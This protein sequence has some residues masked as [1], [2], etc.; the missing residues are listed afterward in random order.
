MLANK[1]KLSYK[2]HSVTG[3]TYTELTGL[4]EGPEWG[5][6]VER[7]ETT[8]LM[9]ISK[10][11]EIGIGDMPEKE[12]TFIVKEKKI[13][14]TS[15]LAVLKTA[16]LAGDVLDFKFEYPDGTTIKFSG[17]IVV[18]ISQV[19]VNAAVGYTLTV[20][21]NSAEEYTWATA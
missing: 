18:K 9:D 19:S 8:D 16:E 6:D 1:S 14:S 4:Q 13:T 15:Q 3:E 17:E 2:K 10:T 7:V 11:Y 12:F 21:L 5:S 20:T